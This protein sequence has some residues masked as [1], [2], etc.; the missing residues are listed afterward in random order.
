M[1]DWEKTFSEICNST[2]LVL[3]IYITTSLFTKIFPEVQ[4]LEKILT[5]MGMTTLSSALPMSAYNNLYKSMYE[6]SVPLSLP[7]LD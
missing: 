6:N 3:G 5:L 2:V 7:R 4:G 1:K